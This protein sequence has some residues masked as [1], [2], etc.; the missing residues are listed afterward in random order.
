MK[1]KARKYLYIIIGLFVLGGLYA[2]SNTS[3]FVRVLGFVVSITIFYS[4]DVFFNL[5]FKNSHYVIFLA[6]T[7]TGILFSPFYYIYP[8]YDKIL[9]LISP[10]LICIILFH[11][12][13]RLNISFGLKVYFTFSILVSL[14]GVWE[15]S[16]FLVD[17]FF[18]STLQGV[19]INDLTAVS[20]LKL[21]MDK[22][23][24]TMTDMILGT[25]GSIVFVLEKTAANY[26]KKLNSNKKNKKKN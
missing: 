22:H 5:K 13:N 26:I 11:L 4:A 2:L 18:G 15:V 1:T 17:R 19:Y 3:Y 9:H 23:D 24:D 14:L 21:I 10:F 20:K 16:E 6:I 12:I 25:I 7:T 8:I